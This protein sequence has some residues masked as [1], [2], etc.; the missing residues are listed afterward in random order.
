MKDTYEAAK[1]AHAL[2]LITEWP[3][4]CSLD[5]Q[6]IFDNMSK[7]AFIFD[8]RNHLDHQKLFEIGFNVYPIGRPPLTHM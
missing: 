4:Y 7:P 2:A 8:G 3:E 6:K 1:D 5:Y